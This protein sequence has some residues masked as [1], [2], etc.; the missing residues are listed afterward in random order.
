MM[1]TLARHGRVRRAFKDKVVQC[2]STIPAG[3]VT[4]SESFV[5]YLKD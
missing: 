1:L 2:V 4:V 5:L 3:N